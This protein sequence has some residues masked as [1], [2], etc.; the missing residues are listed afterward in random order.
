M[1]LS[2]I[3]L[4]ATVGLASASVFASGGG[5]YGG[6]GG[7]GFGSSPPKRQI[8]QTYEVGKAIYNGRQSGFPKLSY[9]VL[10]DGEKV[11]VKSKSIKQYKKSS[12]SD[13]SASLYNCDTP[14]NLV[15]N[16]LSRDG[17]LHV[18]YYLNK[19]YRLSLKSS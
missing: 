4:A 16:E 3:I 15:A 6:G 19:R 14:D 8:D 18:L 10:S 7:G 17:L 2:K 12:Y 11:P 9:C 13:L 1:K 5:G